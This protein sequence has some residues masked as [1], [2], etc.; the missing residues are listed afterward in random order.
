MKRNCFGFTLIELLV[1]IAII[2][3]LAAI[4]FPILTK[5]K[6]TSTRAACL[7][8]LKQLGTTFSLYMDDNSGNLPAMSPYTGTPVAFASWIPRI[9]KYA[10]SDKIFRC[11]SAVQQW[12]VVLRM[13]NNS[14]K[15]FKTSYSYNEYLHWT[16]YGFYT[17]SNIRNV[18]DVALAADGYQMAL[19]HDW[20]DAG[21]WPN[22][23]GLPSGMNRI[24]YADGPKMVDGKA[25]WDVPLVRHMG[26]NIVFC[27]LHV[28]QVDKEKFKAV[29]Y[30]GANYP[31]SCREYPV[32]YPKATRF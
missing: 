14:W 30:P 18:K 21:A 31:S 2:A 11:P 15:A 13:P 9:Y 28:E 7:G 26:P 10:K 19:F 5:A 29:N 25:N 24:R 12:S 32:V 1:V 8:N 6:E 27:D 20:N 22:K 4:L 16:Q 3:I 23:D 17:M